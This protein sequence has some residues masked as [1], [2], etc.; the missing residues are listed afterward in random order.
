MTNRDQQGQWTAGAN[1]YG[2]ENTGGWGNPTNDITS[3]PR[4]NAP[5]SRFTSLGEIASTH[6]GRRAAP[7]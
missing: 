4:V 3:A 2:M 7:A 6:K 5:Q 1:E